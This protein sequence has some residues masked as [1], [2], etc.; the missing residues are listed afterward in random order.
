MGFETIILN[1][2]RGLATIALNRPQQL[3][4]LN[5]RMFTE[6]DEALDGVEAFLEKRTPNFTGRQ[7]LGAAGWFSSWPRV[8]RS[9]AATGT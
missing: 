5:R 1:I 3:N 6:L 2:E 7:P 8:S 9:S 4:A